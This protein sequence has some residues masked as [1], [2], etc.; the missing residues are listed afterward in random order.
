MLKNLVYTDL[1]ITI[2]GYLVVEIYPC[3]WIF[4]WIIYLLRN[5]V[6]AHV[7]CTVHNSDNF[8]MLYNFLI[9]CFKITAVLEILQL[10]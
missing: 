9:Q 5:T 3:F 1:Y 7:H 4:N 2:P 10:E 6:L 8:N